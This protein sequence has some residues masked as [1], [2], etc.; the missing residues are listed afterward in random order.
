MRTK[1]DAPESYIQLPRRQPDKRFQKR[2]RILKIASYQVIVEIGQVDI[3]WKEET[4][5][6]EVGRMES[7][8]RL[9]KKY[10]SGCRGENK[11][12][13]M[14]KGCISRALWLITLNAAKGSDNNW[15]IMEDLGETHFKCSSSYKPASMLWKVNRRWW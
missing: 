12:T 15:Y 8:R 11:V 4:K 10:Q 3:N 1:D 13:G 7:E 2:F 9:R 5:I 6:P 14:N